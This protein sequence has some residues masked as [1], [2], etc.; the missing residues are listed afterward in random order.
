LDDDPSDGELAARRRRRVR[1]IRAQ[2]LQTGR[3]RGILYWCDTGLALHV[4]D[5][6]YAA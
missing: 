5:A 2:K 4:H 3:I 6:A 1:V